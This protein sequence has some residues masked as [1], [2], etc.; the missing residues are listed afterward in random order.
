MV[1]ESFDL[2]YTDITYFA[3][4]AFFLAEKVKYILRCPPEV[5]SFF[6]AF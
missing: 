2:S 1:V 5:F 4:L 3:T 6:V